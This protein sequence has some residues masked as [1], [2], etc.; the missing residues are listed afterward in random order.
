MPNEESEWADQ[1]V[2]YIHSFIQRDKKDFEA[3]KT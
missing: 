1:A 2:R 3:E